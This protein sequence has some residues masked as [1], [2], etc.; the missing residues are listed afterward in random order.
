MIFLGIVLCFVQKSHAKSNE[1]LTFSVNYYKNENCV[2]A[3]YKKDEY[4]YNCNDFDN[5]D[6]CCSSVLIKNEKQDNQIINKCYA[7]NGTSYMYQCSTQDNGNYS[8]RILFISIFIAISAIFLIFIGVL[9]YKYKITYDF[10]QKQ[11]MNVNSYN[12]YSSLDNNDT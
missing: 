10:E 7:L 8:N 3:S 2:N 1:I 4:N 11:L 6:Q 5:Y 9:I 12:G